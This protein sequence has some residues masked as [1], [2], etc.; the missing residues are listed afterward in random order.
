[1][2]ELGEN[3][4]EMFGIRD[5][6][7]KFKDAIRDPERRA[8]IDERITSFRNRGVLKSYTCDACNDTGAKSVKSD[9][10]FWRVVECEECDFHFE[11]KLGIHERKRR[12]RFSDLPEE[13]AD[14][15]FENFKVTS[16]SVA[17]ALSTARNYAE[18]VLPEP[19]I[20]LM[21]KPGVGKS[22][23]AASVVNW[24]IMQ[25]ESPA[26]KWLVVPDWMDAMRAGIKSGETDRLKED[27][28]D[29][30][31][32]VMDDFGAEYHKRGAESWSVEQLY[33]V[34]NH[35]YNHNLQ[36]VFTTDLTI[37]QVGGRIPDRLLD[38]GSGKVKVVEVDAPSYRTGR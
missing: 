7:T 13:M 33:L 21:G 11:R 29:A 37:K 6:M 20:L 17:N 34:V 12:R 2:E 26:A 10:G 9:E 22:H 30:P 36:T 23:L 28:I 35:R 19:W 14:A 38:C 4:E 3:L 1:M 31:C 32:L 24:R 18:G 15:T 27:I 25:S 8:R 5:P 16:E